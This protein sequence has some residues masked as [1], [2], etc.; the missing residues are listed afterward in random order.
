MGGRKTDIKLCPQKKYHDHMELIRYLSDILAAK[1]Y[2][3]YFLIKE[4]IFHKTSLLLGKQ[5]H[6]FED[7]SNFSYEITSLS[8]DLIS[9]YVDDTSIER[10]LRENAKFYHTIGSRGYRY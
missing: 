4:D 7:N 9:R 2:Y 6:I 10:K 8:R 3:L 1:E 5:K